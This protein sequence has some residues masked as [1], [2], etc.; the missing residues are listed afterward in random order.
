MTDADAAPPFWRTFAFWALIAALVS[1]LLFAIA[2]SAGIAVAT[3]SHTPRAGLAVISYP[4]LAAPPAGVLALA[5]WALIVLSYRR[6]ETERSQTFR[7]AAVGIA[8]VMTIV[9]GFLLFA[10]LTAG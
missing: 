5:A 10:W 8:I 1:L 2:L 6:R 9:V 7:F 3:L 4:L